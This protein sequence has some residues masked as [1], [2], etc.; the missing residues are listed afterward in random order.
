MQ[1][2]I[3]CHELPA[4]PHFFFAFDSFHSLCCF[5]RSSLNRNYAET[6]SERFRVDPR[7]FLFCDSAGDVE[8]SFCLGSAQ[9]RVGLAASASANEKE[10]DEKS[11]RAQHSVAGYDF[12]RAAALRAVAGQKRA[13]ITRRRGMSGRGGALHFGTLSPGV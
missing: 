4:S 1:I 6:A 9:R 8:F 12:D 2:F 10:T 7:A 13:Q 11:C 5:P 3:S